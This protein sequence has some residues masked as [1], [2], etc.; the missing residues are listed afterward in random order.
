MELLFYELLQ[1]TFSSPQ[2]ATLGLVNDNDKSI[3]IQNMVL[4]VF[5]LYICKSRV[6]GTL[7]YDT[8]FH[9]L[10][11]VKNLEKGVAF[12]NKQKHD[13]FLKKWSVVVSLS[14]Q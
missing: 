13:V 1:L 4:M 8:F 12:N 5:N 7:S 3:L 9:H 14:S 2:I 10:V 6:N 11:K